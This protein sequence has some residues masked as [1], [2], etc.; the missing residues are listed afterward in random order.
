MLTCLTKI[1]RKLN[2]SLHRSLFPSFCRIV[3]LSLLLYLIASPSIEN[4]NE[5]KVERQTN[6]IK[7]NKDLTCTLPVLL[8]ET[9]GSEGSLPEVPVFFLPPVTAAPSVYH[10]T[11]VKLVKKIIITIRII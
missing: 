10:I 7:S 5:K 6:Q 8:N 1:I 3:Y 4:N 2:L 11:Q 9:V